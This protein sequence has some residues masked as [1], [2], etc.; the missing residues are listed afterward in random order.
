MTNHRI[1]FLKA[2]DPFSHF[3]H[4]AGVFVSHDV[5]EFHIHFLTPDSFDH[6]KVG[7]ANARSSDSHD[8]ICAFFQFRFFHFLQR[9]EFLVRQRSIILMKY[10][11]FHRLR[12][13]QNGSDKQNG[14]EVQDTPESDVFGGA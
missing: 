4:P 2:L 12:E 7:A 9:N 6:M 8:D 3:F 14:R 11:G 1:S 13:G 5:W 10:S